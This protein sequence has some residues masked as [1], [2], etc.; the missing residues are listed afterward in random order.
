MASALVAAKPAY[1]IIPFQQLLVPGMDKY[2]N[3][4]EIK[5]LQGA[6]ENLQK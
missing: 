5:K 2:G 1:A 3:A 4:N 6:K